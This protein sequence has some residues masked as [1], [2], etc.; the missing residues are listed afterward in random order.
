M[1]LESLSKRLE[2]L[3]TAHEPETV[4]VRLRSGEER[5]L[6]K[7]Q[8]MGALRDSISNTVTPRLKEILEVV[9]GRDDH[10]GLLPWIRL[11]SVLHASREALKEAA[12]DAQTD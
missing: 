7:D 9:A 6:S 12:A 4:T 3:E 8:V 1:G 10:A 11:A 5:E 2:E